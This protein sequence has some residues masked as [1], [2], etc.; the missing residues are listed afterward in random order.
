[1]SAAVLLLSFMVWAFRVV[2]A[3]EANA[4][5]VLVF[6]LTAGLTFE[7]APGEWSA[8]WSRRCV[9]TVRADSP[10]RQRCR[11]RPSWDGQRG[12]RALRSRSCYRFG[13]A[14]CQQAPRRPCRLT[15]V[16]LCL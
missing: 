10:G 13:S 6:W 9:C 4:L 11:R 14:R 15:V 7:T 16:W 5:H 3:V 8:L 2:V 1:M 12:R